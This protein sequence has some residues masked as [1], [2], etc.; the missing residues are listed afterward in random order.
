MD[1]AVR[2]VGRN[3]T[4]FSYRDTGWLETI[5]G[6]DMDPA[7]ADVIRNWTIAYWDALHPLSEAGAYVNFM[8]DEGL[9]RV[10]ATYRDNYD[11][12]VEIK[13]RYD[14]TNLFRVN[15]NILPTA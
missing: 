1:G 4:A 5:V 11:R 3:E 12:L 9:D 8:M 13:N 10:R 7:N 14:P 2:R 15:H 6:F